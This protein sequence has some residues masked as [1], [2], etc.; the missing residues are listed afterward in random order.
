MYKQNEYTRKYKHKQYFQCERKL[1][2]TE[3]LPHFLNKIK[4]QVCGTKKWCL[5]A[6]SG[7]RG[8]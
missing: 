6:S 4:I 5:F 8:L 1:I 2:V 7:M 3:K